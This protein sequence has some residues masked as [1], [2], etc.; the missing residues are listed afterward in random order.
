MSQLIDAAP[1]TLTPGQP[2]FDAT[3]A[4]QSIGANPSISIWA[5]ANAGAGKTKVLIDRIA[6]LL[7]DGAQPGRVLAVTYT[8]AAAAEMQTRLYDKLGSW[9]IAGDAQLRAALGELDPTLDLELPGRLARARSLFAAALETPGGLKIQTIHAFCQTILQRFPLEA[10]VPPNFKILDDTTRRALSEQAFEI[11]ARQSPQ[12]FSDIAAATSLDDDFAAIRFAVS[13]RLNIE[14]ARANPVPVRV[15]I[16]EALGLDSNDEPV[17]MRQR[18][19]GRLDFDALLQAAS[20]LKSGKATDHKLAKALVD[21][22]NTADQK[23]AWAQFVKIVRTGEGLTRAK[24]IYTKDMGNHA[25]VV[26]ALGPYEEWPSSF[27][28]QIEEA[29]NNIRACQLMAR[30]EALTRAALAYHQA[31]VGAKQATGSLDFDDLVTATANLLSHSDGAAQWVLYKLDAGIEHI[32]I[33]EAQDTSPEQWDLLAPLFAA[34]DQEERDRPRTRFIVGDEKQSIFS[35]QGARPE[36]F[37]EER[38][39]FEAQSAVYQ[40]GRQALAF[41]LSFRT[42]QTILNAV[43]AVWS[44]SQ[45]EGDPPLALV[46]EADPPFERK[47][48]FS[49]RHSAFRSGQRGAVELW[50]LLLAQKDSSTVEAWDQP[51]NMEREDSARNQLAD[52]IALELKSRLET[53]F[54]VWD[55]GITRPLIPADVMVLVK[56]RGTFFHQLIRRLKFH[57]VPVAGADRIKLV[58]D[59]G[60][61]DLIALGRFALL[62]EDDFNTACV[63]KGAFCGLVDDD[64]H[65]FPLLWQ[66]ENASLW[67]RL[68]SSPDPRHAQASLFLRRLLARAGHFPPYEFFAALLELPLPFSDLTG[69]QALI[70]RLGREVREPVEAFLSRALEHGTTSA[71]GLHAF[72]GQIETDAADI[73]REMDQDGAGVRVMTIH[74]AKG[75]EA[76]FV[77]LP[78][79]TSA[80][81]KGDSN[82]VFDPHAEAFMWSPGSKEDTQEF[83]IKREAVEAQAKGEDARLLYVAMT[84]ARDVLI[85]C[86]HQHGSGSAGM[87]KECWF[88]TFSSAVPLIGQAHKIERSNFSYQMW[89]EYPPVSLDQIGGNTIAAPVLPDWYMHAPTQNPARQRRI[90]P[91][92]LAPQGSEP[93]ALSPLAPDARKRFLRG[94]LIHEL[95]QRLPELPAP[96]WERAALDR[97]AREND[98]DEAARRAIVDETCAVLREPRF[99]ALFGPGSRAEAAIAGTGPGLPADMVVNGSVDRLVVTET[100]VLV[101][102]F[103]TNRPPPLHVADVAQVYLNQMAAYRALLQATWPDKMIRCALLWTDGPR[104]MELPDTALDQALRVIAALPR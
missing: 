70:E 30:S 79:T 67:E 7:L 100:D 32:L 81:Q 39:K 44:L 9:T 36:R 65:L 42:G 26:A 49:T 5:S 54:C 28:C 2:V 90:A 43:D 61:Q 64:A 16:A 27:S 78:D 22:I 88:Q 68:Q 91:S 12:A 11:A 66:R 24:Q 82:I 60:V 96:L 73:K 98:I 31:W 34:L 55:N 40:D 18:A 94:R 77:I 45:T 69:W 6:R 35:F 50:P 92:A 85:I 8:K 14:R 19:I 83:K 25:A 63:L 95:L 57:K 51:Q 59:Q 93:P 23:S 33:D 62:P 102:D 74:G 15:R 99:A 52:R 58:E 75:L 21:A 20:V 13:Q 1:L 72:L 53:G 10:G 48:A 46:S 80:V 41:E 89:G 29:D 84:R 38:G 101:L 104:L 87:P 3:I 56:K 4:A 17:A 97:L 76:P 71:P 86:G 47:Y 37:Y 103:K